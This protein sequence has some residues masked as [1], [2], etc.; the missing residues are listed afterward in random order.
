MQSNYGRMCIFTNEDI[1]ALGS[2][3]TK[4][5]NTNNVFIF[6]FGLI[7]HG[8]PRHGYTICGET[9]VQTK[10]IGVIIHTLHE[11]GLLARGTQV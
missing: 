2:I 1:I 9:H 10:G 4:A 7:S 5:M 6:A 3:T 8:F 11:L